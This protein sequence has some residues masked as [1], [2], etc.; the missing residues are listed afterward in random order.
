MF[1]RHTLCLVVLSTLAGLACKKDPPPAPAPTPAPI[2]ETKA[3]PAPATTSPPQS[4]QQPAAKAQDGSPGEIVGTVHWEGA[5]PKQKKLDAGDP[6]CQNARLQKGPLLSERLTINPNQTVKDVFVFVKR[7]LPDQ[8]WPVPAT[9]VVLD[10]VACQY[11]PHVFGVMVGQSIEIVNSDA[12]AHNINATPKNNT[13]F[14]IGQPAA[15]MRSAKM[16]STP[17]VMVPI[18]CNVHSWMKAWCGVMDHPF[19]AV[20]DSTGQFR[21]S[22]LPPGTYVLET[23]VEHPGLKPQTLEVTV[24]RGQSVEARFDYKRP[25]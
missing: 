3:D 20:T 10:Q 13:A 18:Q 4:P 6:W 19:F 23:W 15:G 2:T 1:M 24:L 7:G 9:P 25:R 17:E 14:N 16:F 12:T 22:G 5:A 8:T 21:I 11:V